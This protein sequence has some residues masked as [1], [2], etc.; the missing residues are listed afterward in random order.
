MFYLKQCL[1]FYVFIFALY[2]NGNIYHFACLMFIFMLIVAAW[3]LTVFHKAAFSYSIMEKFLKDFAII[4]IVFGCTIALLWAYTASIVFF[5]R[6]SSSMFLIL[7]LAIYMGQIEFAAESLESR[8]WTLPM[9]VTTVTTASS[10]ITTITTYLD[11]NI[12]S[13]IVW[14]VRVNLGLLQAIRQQLRRRAQHRIIAHDQ[15]C[16]PKGSRSTPCNV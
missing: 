10:R 5:G 2:P 13:Y 12:L 1:G 9:T 8:A 14:L 6:L 7:C 4:I 16:P 11:R 15:R 3:L